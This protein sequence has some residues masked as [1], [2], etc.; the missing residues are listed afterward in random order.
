M[1]AVPLSVFCE[2]SPTE[3]KLE[4]PST[5]FLFSKLKYHFMSQQIRLAEGEGGAHHFYHN[6]SI[7]M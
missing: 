3:W 5:I 2:F 7:P 4:A 6:P 1:I